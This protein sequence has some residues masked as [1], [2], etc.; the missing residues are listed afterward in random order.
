MSKSAIQSFNEISI[1][2]KTALFDVLSAAIADFDHRHDI[3]DVKK[4]VADVGDATGMAMLAT[5]ELGKLLSDDTPIVNAFQK[6]VR[7]TINP[8][9]VVSTDPKD[10]LDSAA[11]YHPFNKK[12]FFNKTHYSFTVPYLVKLRN[13][14]INY[15]RTGDLD[16]DGIEYGDGFSALIT[17]IV[18]EL[19]H[20]EQGL[21]KNVTFGNRSNVDSKAI[22][23]S[24]S[25]TQKWN[26]KT[27]KYNLCYIINR[28]INLS[29]YVS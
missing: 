11:Y 2:L 1:V 7:K 20:A 24:G 4:Q 17:V 13:V 16:S 10:A 23:A 12:L 25:I 19:Q 28:I 22:Y 5:K 27:H 29:F 15:Y 9:L 26:P 18:H 3:T 6:Y 8:D 14:L 21:H